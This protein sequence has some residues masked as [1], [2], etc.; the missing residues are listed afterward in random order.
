[1]K[2]I[3][4]LFPTVINPVLFYIGTSQQ[5]NHAV[6]D[7][8]EP[9]DLWFHLAD[10]SS[11]HVVAV[12][13]LDLTRKQRGAIIRRGAVLCKMNTRKVTHDVTVTYAAVKHVKKTSVKGQVMIAENESKAI[14]V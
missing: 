9:N 12:I 6:L 14:N 8:G 5:E 7:L 11:C 3:S 1:M 13:P 2:I 10:T 4:T